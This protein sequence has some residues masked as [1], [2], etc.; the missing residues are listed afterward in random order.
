M[1]ELGRKPQ[2]ANNGVHHATI[3]GHRFHL[4]PTQ[5]GAILWLD[6][7]QPPYLLDQTAADFVRLTIE[8]MWRFQQGEGDESNKV[9]EYVVN[10]MIK[11]YRQPLALR[12]RLTRERVKA[13][14][15]KLFG[16]LM[17][18]A[19]G[20]CP[21]DIGLG[22]QQIKPEKWGAPAR[23]DLAVTYRCNLTCAKCY[24]GEP[25]VGAELTTREWL[26]VY[27]KL[28]QLGVPQITFT[29]GEPTLREDIVEL[30][31]EADEFVTGLVT[32]GTRLAELAEPLHNASLDYAQVT[33]ESY[34]P[35]IHDGLTGVVGSHAQTVAGIRAARQVGLQ[36]V[37]NTTLTKSNADHFSET[38]AWLKQ[39]LGIEDIACNTLICS[40][41]GTE[42]R[43]THGLSDPEILEVLKRACQTASDLGVNFQWYS[44]GCYLVVNPLQLGL[45]VKQCSAAAHN[46][47]V[48][49]DGGVLPCQSWPTPVGNILR[50]PW[51][52]IWNDETCRKLR[53]HL[54]APVECKDCAELAVCGG[55]CPLDKSPRHRHQSE[56]EHAS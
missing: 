32:N 35:E 49:P 31:R 42:Y 27:E 25:Q 16:T 38:I 1:T 43:E 2:F 36:V 13:D 47:M 4:R 40:G 45:G 6:G 21:A 11:K 14:L 50:D 37:T 33:I 55:G 18:L 8:A 30:V 3:N 29:G 54:F 28:W 20:T 7:K 39:E 15:D 53:D 24:N 52:K 22:T 19:E 10:E 5:E 9:T 26:Q 48:Q 17:G 34:R 56:G 23:M 12:N 44:P 41:R 51:E 46:M